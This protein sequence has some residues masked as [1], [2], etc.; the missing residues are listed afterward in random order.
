MEVTKIEE[1]DDGSAIVYFEPDILEYALFVRLGHR[2][3][4][5]EF[6]DMICFQIG[7]TEAIKIGMKYD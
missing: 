3:S 4:P 5:L 2:L 6:D 7:V 1:L